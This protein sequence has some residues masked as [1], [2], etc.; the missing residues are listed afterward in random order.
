VGADEEAW[1]LDP[2]LA[3][4]TWDSEGLARLGSIRL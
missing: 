2:W 1:D 3:L 4:C